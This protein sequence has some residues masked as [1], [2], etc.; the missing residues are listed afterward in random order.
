MF[1]AALISQALFFLYYN[2][3]ADSGSKSNQIY[4]LIESSIPLIGIIFQIDWLIFLSIFGYGLMIFEML[5]TTLI[6]VTAISQYFSLR[7]LITGN[8]SKLLKTL[9]QDG[10]SMKIIR[11]TNQI[12]VSF[13][14]AVICFT[15]TLIYYINNIN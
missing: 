3:S 7:N 6:P 12:I 14:F 8:T 4:K 15:T 5:L 13:V 2:F 1:Y 10:V 9:T 11:P